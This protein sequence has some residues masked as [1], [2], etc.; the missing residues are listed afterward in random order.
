MKFIRVLITIEVPFDALDEKKPDWKSEF[1]E[2]AKEIG[3]DAKE[4]DENAEA[5]LHVKEVHKY[6]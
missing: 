4:I 1:E 6:L 3:D 5:T 2:L